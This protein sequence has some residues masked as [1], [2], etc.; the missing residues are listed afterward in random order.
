MTNRYLPDFSRAKRVLIIRLSSIGDVMHALPVAA[1]LKDAYPHLELTWIVEDM[2]EEIVAGA[3]CLK[4]IIVVPRR[5]WKKEG[6]ATSP[7]VWKEYWELI[8]TIRAHR[9][10]VSID[11]QGYA[12]SAAFAL[13]SGAPCR[14]GWRRLRDGSGLVS[15]SIPGRAE[16]IHRV[17]WFLDV[18]RACIPGGELQH[19][20]RFPFYIPNPARIRVSQLLRDAG[21]VGK[22]A[23]INPSVGSANRRW[24]PEKYGEVAVRIARDLGLSIVLVGSSKDREICQSVLK[25]ATAGLETGSGTPTNL[26]DL[27]GETSIKELA[28]VLDGCDIHVCGDTGSAHIA[29]G[30]GIPVVALYGPTDPGYAGPWNQTAGVLAHREYCVT[31]CGVRQC[32]AITAAGKSTETVVARCLSEITPQDVLT[33]IGEVLNAKRQ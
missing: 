3:N 8:R 20:I 24:S 13:A 5:R 10:D 28:A 2:S 1:A 33:R 23:V 4:D 26:A 31:G 11:L 17:D 16:S 29:A 14:I 19:A 18:V 7:K 22:Y 30:L 12:K 6:R 32:A 15:R 21:I 27:S 9:F 25:A